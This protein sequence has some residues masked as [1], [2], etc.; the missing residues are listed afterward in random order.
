M[1][2]I[3]WSHKLGG[4]EVELENTPFIVTE[5][6]KLDCQFG[7]HYYRE[8]KIKRFSENAFARESQKRMCCT[9][10]YKTYCLIS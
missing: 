7:A 1:P 6:R 4:L 10:V 8:K 2:K 5:H 3:F 9:H